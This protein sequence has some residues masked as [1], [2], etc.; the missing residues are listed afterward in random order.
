MKPQAKPLVPVA[1]RC[2]RKRESPAAVGSAVRT[3]DIQPCLTRKMVRTADP[4]A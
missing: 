2:E 4:T 3:N 1:N